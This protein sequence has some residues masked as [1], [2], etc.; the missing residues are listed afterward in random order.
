MK[1]IKLFD[2]TLRDGSQVAG[3][4]FSVEDKLKI[5]RA[6]DAF[7]IHYIEGGWPG[8]NPKDEQFFKKARTLNLRNSKIVA[9]GSTRYKGHRA[10]SDP[11]L[12]AIVKSKVSAACIFGKSWNLHVEHALRTSKDENLKMIAD[13]VAFLKSE[14]LEVLYDAEHFFDGFKNDPDYALATLAAAKSG[15]ADSLNLCETNGGMLPSDIMETVRRVR[16]N[17][18]GV[19]LGIHAHNDSGC[20]AANSIVAVQEGCSIVQGTINGIGE[21]CGNA[22]LC[23]IIPALQLKLGYDCVPE[24]KMQGL[25]ELARYV[26]EIANLVPEDRQPYVG[27]NAFAH[28]AGVHVSAIARDSATYEH[29]KPEQ[30]GNVRRVLVSE[31]SGRSNISHKARELKIDLEKDPE[32]AHKIIALV[33]KSEEKGYQYEDADGSFF[34]LTKKALGEYR[35]FFLLKA[36]RVSVE[37]DEK[38]RMVSEA[39]IKLNI[40]GKEVHTVAEGDGPVNALDNCLRKALEKFFPEIGEVALSDFKV[41]VINAGASTAAKVRVLIESRDSS[42]VWGTIGVSENIIEASWQALVDAVEYKLIK[43]K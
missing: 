14:G 22:N 43:N 28:K 15:G 26:S 23:T 6:L 38:G 16:E 36:F 7:G 2:T 11:N 10:Q 13:S 1:K 24:K 41:R 4:S 21:R 20:A 32:S 34:L 3:V 27:S 17:F 39:T 33:K 40:K 12:L 9:F 37:K 42:S 25:T 8:S 19:E 35:P 30:V 29:I 31:L 5:A 18:P